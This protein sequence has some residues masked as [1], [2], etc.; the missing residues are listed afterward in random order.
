M[1]N[2]L[3]SVAQ[4]EQAASAPQIYEAREDENYG[5]TSITSWKFLEHFI[6]ELET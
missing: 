2:V 6:S 4:M 1:S 5:V 3:H